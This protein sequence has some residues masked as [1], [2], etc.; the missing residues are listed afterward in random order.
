[1]VKKEVRKKFTAWRLCMAKVI[2]HQGCLSLQGL[3]AFCQV[4]ELEKRGEGLIPLKSSIW[5]EGDELLR[6]VG[7]PLFKIQRKETVFGE[8][9][10]L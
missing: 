7:Y 9:V 1:M 8:L 10:W 3:E 5:R 6:K 4:E 2:A